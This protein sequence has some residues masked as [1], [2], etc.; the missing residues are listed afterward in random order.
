MMTV[1]V[2]HPTRIT[3]ILHLALMEPDRLV[4]PPLNGV[5]VMRYQDECLTG[6]TELGDPILTLRDEASVTHGEYLIDQKDIGVGVNSDTKSEA[7]EHSRGVCPYRIV[8]DMLKL[9]EANDIVE[10]GVDLLFCESVHDAREHKILSTREIRMKAR[11][12]FDKRRDSTSNVYH[13]TGGLV[14]SSD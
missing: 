2:D 5:E 7:H 6:P 11:A 13:A 8:D 4:T 10:P 14:D 9:G 3:T 12:K 1:R